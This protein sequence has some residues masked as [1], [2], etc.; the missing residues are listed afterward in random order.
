MTLKRAKDLFLKKIGYVEERIA[1]GV[2]DSTKSFLL[3][4]KA[5]YLIAISLIDDALDHN[6][7]R[8]NKEEYNKPRGVK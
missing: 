3:S 4:E 8:F 1:E 7:D 2:R 6:D 5:A